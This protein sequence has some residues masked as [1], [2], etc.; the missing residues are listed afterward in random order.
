MQMEEHYGPGIPKA[1]NPFMLVEVY[2]KVY[3]AEGWLKG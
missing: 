2:H 1:D 3:F